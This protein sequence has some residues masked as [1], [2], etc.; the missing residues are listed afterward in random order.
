LK[1]QSIESCGESRTPIGFDVGG[2]APK[3][4]EFWRDQHKECLKKKGHQ[5][6]A[7]FSVHG[8]IS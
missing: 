7:P 8:F 2:F 5:K 4:P 1:T 3:P 6:D